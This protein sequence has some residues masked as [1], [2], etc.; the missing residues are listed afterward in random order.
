MAN[1][2]AAL[3][4]CLKLAADSQITVVRGKIKIK[5]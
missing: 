4:I 1:P 2:P 5:E 3:L